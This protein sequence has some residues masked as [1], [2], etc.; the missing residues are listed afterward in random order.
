MKNRWGYLHVIRWVWVGMDAWV[1]AGVDALVVIHS[2]T[3]V[4]LR[5]SSEY[6]IANIYYQLIFTIA[7]V[8]GLQ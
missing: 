7:A 5:L 3:P 2:H 1:W 6:S 4:V 8:C